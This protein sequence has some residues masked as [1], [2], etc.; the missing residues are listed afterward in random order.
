MIRGQENSGDTVFWKRLGESISRRSGA[1]FL[2]YLIALVASLFLASG[3]RPDYR[4][5]EYLPEGNPVVSA[6]NDV[7]A[8]FAGS[9]FLSVVI[10][11]E[12]GFG[13]PA[14]SLPILS[15]LD[16]LLRS[17]FEFGSLRSLHTLLESF[18][19]EGADPEKKLN[20]ILAEF[21]EEALSGIIGAS[22]KR[23]R[24]SIPIPEL[25]SGETKEIIER[26]DEA[27]DGL[28]DAHPKT[29][30]YIVGFPVLSA[31]SSSSMISELAAS[32]VIASLVIFLLIGLFFRSA[33]LGIATLL[34]NVLPLA[35]TA[36]VLFLFGYPLQYTSV[37]VFTICLGIAVDDS[38]HFLVSY[39]RL[40]KKSR[41]SDDS[42]IIGAMAEVG[43]AISA[44]SLILISGLVVLIFSQVPPTR[45]F[46]QL[47]C[48]A[49]LWALIADLSFLPASLSF[50][51]KIRDRIRYTP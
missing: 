43:P 1:I 33:G 32:L 46:G 23:I 45:L 15:E 44:T 27:L 30:F 26:L 8:Q 47:A 36:A 9:S 19:V 21:P 14:E 10:E 5:S 48:L 29:Q 11:R 41:S 18:P 37:L 39:R 22:G 50:G 49:I 38:I 6:L 25:W 16:E 40:C 51:R 7:D 31:E 42:T 4:Y 17:D 28:R 13:H 3:L 35:F 24:L 2:L 20:Q 12:E 34:P